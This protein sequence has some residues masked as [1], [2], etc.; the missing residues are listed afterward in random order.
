MTYSVY[1]VEQTKVMFDILQSTYFLFIYFQK[2]FN[3]KA[4]CLDA[5]NN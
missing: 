5:R 3:S 2:L 4:V 1:C